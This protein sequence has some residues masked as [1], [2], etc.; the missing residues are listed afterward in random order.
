MINTIKIYI[1]REHDKICLLEKT[2]KNIDTNSDPQV[3]TLIEI[4][5]SNYIDSCINNNVMLS[6]YYLNL[7]ET[8]IEP[9]EPKVMHDI[10]LLTSSIIYQT[11]LSFHIKN[12]EANSNIIK[13]F[14]QQKKLP[15]I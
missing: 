7:L 11:P 4:N 13:Y 1:T 2:I 8:T 10:L 9:F 15:L 5:V 14:L 3:I 12:N 6:K